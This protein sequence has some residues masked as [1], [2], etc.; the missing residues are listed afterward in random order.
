MAKSI[1][2][3]E[4][5]VD[6]LQILSEDVITLPEVAKEVPRSSEQKP[7]HYSTV[8]RWVHKGVRGHKLATVKV[9]HVHVTS[10]QRLHAFL[11]AI[12]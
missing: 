11:K 1:Q 6:R 9:G 10:R 3:S 5:R 8:F 4:G 12:N 7:L 2:S